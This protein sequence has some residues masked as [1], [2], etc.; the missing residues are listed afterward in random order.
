MK[1]KMK[2]L[3]TLNELPQRATYDHNLH[4]TNI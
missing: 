2:K 1:F 3:T 4:Q